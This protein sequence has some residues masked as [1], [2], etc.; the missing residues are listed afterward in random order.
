VKFPGQLTLFAKYLAKKTRFFRVS[1]MPL[2]T[3]TFSN[4]FQGYLNVLTAT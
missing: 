3:I 2:T 4:T 1:G